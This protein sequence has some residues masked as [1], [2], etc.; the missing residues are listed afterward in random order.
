ME[1]LLHPDFVEFD[2]SGRGH[3]RADVLEEFG[4]GNALLAIHSRYF[5]LIDLAQGVALLT[6]LSAHLDARGNQ[7]RHTLRYSA[8]VR[9]A[10]GWQLWVSS[11]NTKLERANCY[12]LTCFGV[13]GGEVYGTI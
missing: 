6:Y 8:W 5:D 2:R 10:V 12:S 1:K 3:T 7:H 9:N 11:G 13:F 4:A